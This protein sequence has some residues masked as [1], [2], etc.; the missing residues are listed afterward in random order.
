MREVAHHHANEQPFTRSLPD[1]QIPAGVERITVQGRDQR[2]GWGG[3]TVELEVPADPA[4][5][6]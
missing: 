4:G 2:Y 5:G 3:G 6:G 1:L